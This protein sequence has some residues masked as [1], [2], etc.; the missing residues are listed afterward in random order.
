[1][2]NIEVKRVVQSGPATVVFF[3]D[4]TKSVT[5]LQPG[6][7]YDPVAGVAWAVCKRIAKGCGVPV[8]DF[9]ADRLDIEQ[10]TRPGLDMSN[11]AAKI[12]ASTYLGGARELTR[13]VSNS[14]SAR[15]NETRRQSAEVADRVAALWPESAYSS[16]EHRRNA[17]NN[18]GPSRYAG[19]VNAFLESGLSRTEHEYHTTA[20]D[21]S[22]GRRS[23]TNIQSG[24]LSYIRCHGLSGK[25]AV[26]SRGDTVC[27]SRRAS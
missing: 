21:Y 9:V 22:V 11:D 20:E 2:N 10:L 3:G 12:I 1:M 23:V 13:M 16:E 19:L 18:R 7:S 17:G 6:D 24:I 26:K 8:T 14:V 5:R 4:G 15:P 25:L 27:L